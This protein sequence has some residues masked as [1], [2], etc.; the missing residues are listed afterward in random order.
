MPIGC[1]WRFSAESRVEILNAYGRPSRGLGRVARLCQL[2]DLRSERNG[3]SMT[4][5]SL[6]FVGSV[7][8]VN[9]LTVLRRVSAL[10]AAPINILVS[11]IMA[12]QLYTQVR[13]FEASQPPI[14]YAVGSLLFAVAYAYFAA[15][16]WAGSEGTGSGWFCGWAA[17][18]SAFISFEIFTAYD[19][20]RFGMVWLSWVVLFG[21]FFALS[22]LGMEKVRSALGALTIVQ[23]F[24]TGMIPGALLITDAWTSTSPLVIGAMQLIA[25]L[26]FVVVVAQPNRTRHTADPELVSA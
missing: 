7:L 18:A 8:L 1:M 17:L 11:I 6:F 19:D 15:E 13:T 21:G 20:V 5:I 22:A 3:T 25:P 23:S 16:N 24:T 9:G 10:S 12:A 2:I 4:I 26:V 14:V